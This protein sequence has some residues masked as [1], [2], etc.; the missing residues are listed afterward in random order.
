M[1]DLTDAQIAEVTRDGGQ[2][3]GKYALKLARAAIA[4]DRALN[5]PAGRDV[6][7]GHLRDA[8]DGWNA[9]LA[10]LRAKV[11]GLKTGQQWEKHIPLNAVLALIDKMGGKV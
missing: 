6:V 8:K 9:A 10:E 5:A 4:A 1:K 11:E 3:Y 7:M 2:N